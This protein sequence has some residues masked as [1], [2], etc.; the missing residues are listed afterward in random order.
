MGE[1]SAALVG[2]TAVFGP[3]SPVLGTRYR[4]EIAPAVGGLSSTRVL[5]D[6]RRYVMPARPFTLAAR[7]VHLGQYG[8]DANDPR[9]VPTFLGSR[10][11]VRGYG[12]SS[13]RC[14]WD[15]QGACG[16]LEELLGSRL[17][18]ANLELRMPLFGL[19]SRDIAYGPIP[20]EAFL[21][22]DNGAVWSRVG[23]A[24]SSAPRGDHRRVSSAGAGVRINAL[25]IP[26]EVAAVR[27]FDAP[28]RGWSFDFAFRTGF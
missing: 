28:A 14:E 17:A 12:W 21:F 23:V 11:F 19:R 15:A 5:L 25:G 27:A 18:V 24:G 9:L 26:L 16:A 8:P 7:V 10:Y 4:F 20:A 3:T 2:D 13:L 6:Y 22:A 1:V